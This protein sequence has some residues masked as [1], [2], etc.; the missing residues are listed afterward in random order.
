[1]MFNDSVVHFVQLVSASAIQLCDQLED[2]LSNQTTNLDNIH[3]GMAIKI[4]TED[5]GTNDKV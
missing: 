4:A 3:D 2:V 1:M 5:T